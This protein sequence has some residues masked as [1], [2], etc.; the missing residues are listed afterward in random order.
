MVGNRAPRKTAGYGHVP[1]SVRHAVRRARGQLSVVAALALALGVCGATGRFTA[2]GASAL[3]SSAVPARASGGHTRLLAATAPADTSPSPCPPV[4]GQP[5]GG[6]P[7]VMVVGDSISQGSSGDYTWRYRLYKHLVSDGLSPQ[8]AGPYNWLFNN[9][10]SVQGDCSYADPVFEN[11]HD[12]VWGQMLATAMTTIQ[13]Q[14]ATYQPGYLLV[15][16]GINDLAFGTSDVPGTEAHLKT[17]ISNA[18]AANPNIKI[19]RASCRERV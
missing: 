16:I 12:A 19:G 7:K 6:S 10:T 13:N 18:Q 14:V 17:F 9:V 1:G 11:A 15:L 4:S 3:A 5:A 2:P 8:M